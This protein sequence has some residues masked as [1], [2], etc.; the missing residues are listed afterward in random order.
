MKK[1]REQ[2]LF[3]QVVFPSRAKNRFAYSL[4]KKDMA[5]PFGAKDL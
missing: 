5:F 2:S 1:N 3:L 4:G